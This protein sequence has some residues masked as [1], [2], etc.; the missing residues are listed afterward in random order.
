MNPCNKFQQALALHASGML[1][2]FDHP[3]LESHLASCPTCK[4]QFNELR[5]V[6][7]TLAYQKVKEVRPSLG[8]H[9][10][11][12][13]AI[14]SRG[15]FYPFDWRWLGP[16]AAA[17]CL[18]MSLFFW[19]T[20]PPKA[21]GNAGPVVTVGAEETPPPTLLAYRSALSASDSDLEY[22]LQRQAAKILPNEKGI[23]VHGFN[24]LLADL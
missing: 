3:A 19:S 8:F 11:L 1:D 20:H 2:E 6:C 7:E 21:P 18:A 10:R 14:L 16:V 12:E 24:R 4:A 22:L 13:Q 23:N 17:A 5:V 15:K 9:S